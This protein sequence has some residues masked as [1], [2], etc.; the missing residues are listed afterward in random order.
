ML[1]IYTDQPPTYDHIL[2]LFPSS[3]GAARGTVSSHWN[4]VQS[5][6]GVR[7]GPTGRGVTGVAWTP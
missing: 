4:A 1:A 3:S 5:S 6:G 2:H 7:V